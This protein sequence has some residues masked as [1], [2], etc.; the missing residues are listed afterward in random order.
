MRPIKRACMRRKIIYMTHVDYLCG[1]EVT[2]IHRY[3]LHRYCPD[4][5]N[6][7]ASPAGRRLREVPEH[8]GRER[9][10]GFRRWGSE[11]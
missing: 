5:R 4:P 10:R 3:S 8:N 1:A 9:H 6:L 11:T 7:A 2:S